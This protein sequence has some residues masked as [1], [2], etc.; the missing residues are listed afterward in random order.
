[1]EPVERY[2]DIRG[3]LCGNGDVGAAKGCGRRAVHLQVADDEVD[4]LAGIDG[5]VLDR[6]AQHRVNCCQ[7]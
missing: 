3:S 4:S 5:A 7:G 6:R 2:Q 1:M